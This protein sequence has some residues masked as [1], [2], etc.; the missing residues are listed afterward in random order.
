MRLRAVSLN[1][2]VAIALMGNM[3]GVASAGTCD[4]RTQTCP[5][6]VRVPSRLYPTIQSAVD[7]IPDGSTVNLAPGTYNETVRIEGKRI[8]IIGPDPEEGAATI[9]GADRTQGTITFARTGGGVLRGLVVQGGAFGIAGEGEAAA[10]PSAVEI[11]ETS[12]SNTRK[13]IFGNFSDLAVSDSHIA[14]TAGNGV[15]IM[16]AANFV[17][18][19]SEVFDVLGCGIVVLDTSQVSVDFVDVAFNQLG[20][21]CIRDS[22]LVGVINS[23]VFGNDIAGIKILSSVDVNIFDTTIGFNQPASD[24]RFGDGVDVFLSGYVKLMNTYISNNARAGL[25]NF[26]SHVQ[27]KDNQLC[28]NAFDFE[29]EQYQGQD[30]QFENLGGNQCGCPIPNGDCQVFSEGIEPPDP[31]SPDA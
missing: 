2:I 20:G 24:G 25:A 22:G 16:E 30:F 23:V 19:D 21:I 9:I 12:I 8:S 13:G 18:H 29:G 5:T 1:A 6:T 11:A 28:C 31:L 7:A 15:S 26:G 10:L 14:K 17:I 3:A 4:S 27:I